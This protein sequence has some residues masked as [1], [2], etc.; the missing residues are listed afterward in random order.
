MPTFVLKKYETVDDNK[1][2]ASGDQT[3]QAATKEG[4]KVEEKAQMIEISASDSI[5]KIVAQALYK[6]M[7]NI[8]ITERQMDE[9]QAEGEDKPAAT[10][11]VS[12]EEINQSPVDA[13]ASLGTSKCVL[14][15]NNGFKT[16]QEEWFLNTLQNRGVKTFYTVNSFV[17][18]VQKTLAS[19]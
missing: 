13:L 19:A 12:A 11:V 10:S 3:N 9:E 4:E 15:L 8:D 7:P 18:Y 1:T 17:K 2:Q 5:S 6:A 14:I 16:A